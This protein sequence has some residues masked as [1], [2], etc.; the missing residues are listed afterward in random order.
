VR[1]ELI[2]IIRRN[3]GG[4]SARDLALFARMLTDAN[5]LEP[6]EQVID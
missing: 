2:R 5:R 3:L 6:D 1:S 4:Y